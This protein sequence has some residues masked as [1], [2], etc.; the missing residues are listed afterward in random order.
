MAETETIT[1]REY[2]KAHGYGPLPEAAE[3]ATPG[4]GQVPHGWNDEIVT[5]AKPAGAE[6][7]GAGR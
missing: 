3:G 5:K 1:R 6:N 7:R 4:E 2:R